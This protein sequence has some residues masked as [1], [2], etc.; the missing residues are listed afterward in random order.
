MH[1]VQGGGFGHVLHLGDSLCVIQPS[2][3][4][5]TKLE[6]G[7]CVQQSR[8]SDGEEGTK[9]NL[10]HERSGTNLPSVPGFMFSP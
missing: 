10:T 5:K 3:Y 7:L 6:S 1:S 9:G 2:V 4:R 8:A